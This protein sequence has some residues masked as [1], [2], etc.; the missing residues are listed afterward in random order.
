[1]TEFHI[2]QRVRVRATGE[3]GLI[4]AEDPRH[5]RRFTVEIGHAR[6]GEGPPP[7]FRTGTYAGD[8]LEPV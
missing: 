5:W 3:V 6:R 8:E 4:I 1:M 7:A 2:G